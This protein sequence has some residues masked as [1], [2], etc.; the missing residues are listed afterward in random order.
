M[1]TSVNRRWDTACVRTGRICQQ[2][3]HT[4]CP[5]H[6]AVEGRGKDHRSAIGGSG[7]WLASYF[8]LTKEIAHVCTAVKHNWQRSRGMNAGTKG[9]EDEFGNRNQ[10]ASNTYLTYEQVRRSCNIN[11]YPYLGH[12]FRVSIPWSVLPES[13]L[14]EPWGLTSSPSVT[15]M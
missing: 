10:N 2:N 8:F 15:T 13:I 4:L 3:H 1:L 14:P 6:V 9:G 5:V 12:Q 7:Q 11:V